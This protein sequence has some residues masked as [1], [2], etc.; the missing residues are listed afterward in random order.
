MSSELQILRTSVAAIQSD[1]NH[2]KV[3]L[4][5]LEERAVNRSTMANAQSAR[6]DKMESKLSRLDLK[7]AAAMG[8]VALI[9]W[10]F[11]LLVPV[12]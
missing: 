4:A 11:Q 8:G 10:G 9:A 7:I 6:L 1:V 3:C 2:I 5:R 12:I